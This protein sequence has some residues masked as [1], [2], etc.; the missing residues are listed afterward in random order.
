MIYTNERSIIRSFN[1]ISRS[2]ILK[3]FF[4]VVT[5]PNPRTIPKVFVESRARFVPLLILSEGAELNDEH[6]GT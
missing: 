4:D 6:T 3:K 5:I 2:A 1:L